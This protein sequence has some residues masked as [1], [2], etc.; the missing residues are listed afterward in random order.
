LNC[1]LRNYHYCFVGHATQENFNQRDFCI[2]GKDDPFWEKC[3]YLRL[4]EPSE[5]IK[6]PW[7]RPEDVKEYEDF[8]DYFKISGRELSA[9]FLLERAEAYLAGEYEGNLNKIGNFFDF[10]FPGEEKIEVII[11]NKSLKGFIEFFKKNKKNCKIGCGDCSYCEEVSKKVVKIDERLRK[12]YINLLENL[13]KERLDL[14]EKFQ[15][16]LIMEQGIKDK[17]FTKISKIFKIYS[18][19]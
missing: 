13:I 4:K 19:K 10:Q 16:P 2:S 18:K 8:V 14:K 1:P 17:F 7:I 3:Y 15:K 9:K 12:K 6:S 11:E 5:F